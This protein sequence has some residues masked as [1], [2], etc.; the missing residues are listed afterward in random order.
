MKEI[1]AMAIEL[2]EKMEKLQY[3]EYR[4]FSDAQKEEYDTMFSKLASFYEAFKLA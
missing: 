4:Y 3:P 1:K 2:R